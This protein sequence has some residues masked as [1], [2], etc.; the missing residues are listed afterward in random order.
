MV[1][2]SRSYENK[3]AMLKRTVLCVAPSPLVGEGWGEGEQLLR[4]QR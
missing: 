1:A 3:D 4:V 2:A